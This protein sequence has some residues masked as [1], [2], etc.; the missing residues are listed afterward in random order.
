MLK[1]IHF[2]EDLQHEPCY[3]KEDKK[4]I[5]N[6]WEEVM[7]PLKRQ[8]GMNWY[9][10]LGPLVVCFSLNMKA[11][12]IKYYPEYS[13]HNLCR[14]FPCLTATL[15]VHG[16][17]ICPNNHN[18]RYVDEARFI[19]EKAYIPIEGDLDIDQI[20]W[21]YEKFFEDTKEKRYE[22]NITE[23]ED[24]VW[25][26]G[27]TKMPEKIEYALKITYDRLKAHDWW[28]HFLSSE[29]GQYVDGGYDKWFKK[30]EESA[31]NGNQLNT[32]FETELKKHKLERIP[33][34]NILF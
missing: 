23:F 28:F 2:L 15:R 11:Y 27:W 12:S 8:R 17:G 16:R 31:W 5:M 30:L 22:G 3:T 25:I 34:R 13:V 33:E 32:I 1:E 20:I 19:K 24:M 10:R 6:D 4:V 18:E 21:G 9:N 7:R 29:N 14:E 26:C